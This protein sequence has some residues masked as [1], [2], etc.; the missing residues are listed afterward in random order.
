MQPATYKHFKGAILDIKSIMD[1]L[2]V[3]SIMPLNKQLL[4]ELK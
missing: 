1:T 4:C 2:L 3:F